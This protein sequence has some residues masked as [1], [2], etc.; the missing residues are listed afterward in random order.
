V[1]YYTV[2]HLDEPL[3]KAGVADRRDDFIREVVAEFR[4]FNPRPETARVRYVAP[5]QDFRDCE[6]ASQAED[7]P[8]CPY[9]HVY[10]SVEGQ[11]PPKLVRTFRKS[12][13]VE[14][15]P[16]REPY[17]LPADIREALI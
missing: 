4:S 6:H 5:G 10:A 2:T 3:G 7:M 16:Q 11:A 9:A 1:R 15:V 12:R 14:R 13:K 17:I 8:G